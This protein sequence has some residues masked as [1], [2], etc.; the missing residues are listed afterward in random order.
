MT[1]KNKILLLITGLFIVLIAGYYLFF[2]S[3]SP[4]TTATNLDLY[5]GD[6]D[7]D[8]TLDDMMTTAMNSGGTVAAGGLQWELTE[9]RRK[10]DTGALKNQSLWEIDGEILPASAL[11]ATIDSTHDDKQGSPDVPGSIYQELTATIEAG[12]QFIPGDD[13]HTDIND[14]IAALEKL[15]ATAAAYIPTGSLSAMWGLFNQLKVVKE[16]F[17]FNN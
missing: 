13:E 12:P 2:Y 15:E 11:L 5:T 8:R 14:D 1:K 9:A 6:P 4:F 3:P 7:H 16:N 10:L 17:Y